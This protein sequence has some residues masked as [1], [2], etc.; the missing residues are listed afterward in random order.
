MTAVCTISDASSRNEI[1]AVAAAV[2]VAITISHSSSASVL[3]QQTVTSLYCQL[4]HCYKH[5]RV[6]KHYY[7]LPL[8][9]R[10]ECTVY[11]AYSRAD[12]HLAVTKQQLHLRQLH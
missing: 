2:A 1:A 10:P 3:L 11:V 5:L 4:M 6:N 7:C 8:L 12:L 9:D